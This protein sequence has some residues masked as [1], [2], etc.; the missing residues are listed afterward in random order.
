[1]KYEM[2][3]GRIIFNIFNS[4]ILLLTAVLCVIPLVNVLAVSLSSS[5]AAAANQVSLIP[6]GFNLSAFRYVLE[7]SAFWA[8]FYITIKRCFLGIIINVIIS[9]LMAYPLSK[10]S[11]ELFGRNIYMGI[12]IFAMLFNGGLVPFMLTMKS[13]GLMDNIWGLVLP[14]AVP[15][16]SIILVMNNIRMLPKEIEESARMDGASHFTVLFRIIVPMLGPVIATITLFSFVNHYNSWFDGLVLMN[17]IRKYPLQTFLSQVVRSI[18][19]KSM[20]ETKIYTDINNKTLKAAQLFITL[21]PI[22]LVYPFLQKYF[23]KGIIVG[24]VKG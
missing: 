2:S 16:F 24:S 8:S 1:M 7:R 22:L 11:K 21:V 17:D 13:L 9:V 5:T 18:D 4:A 10:S 12:L 20:E 3:I 15:I 19:V 6:V 23:T 14:A